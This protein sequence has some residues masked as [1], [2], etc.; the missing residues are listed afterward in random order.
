MESFHVAAPSIQL[1]ITA[2]NKS[3][4]LDSVSIP[5]DPVY[6]RDYVVVSTQL[7]TYVYTKT[8]SHH[9]SYLACTKCYSGKLDFSSIAIAQ[10]ACGAYAAG[11]DANVPA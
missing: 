11:D 8:E 6:V 7:G 10:D 4:T 2:K 3:N 9:A 1:A 5:S